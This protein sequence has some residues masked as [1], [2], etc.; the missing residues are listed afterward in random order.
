MA[1]INPGNE[2]Q[3]WSDSEDKNSLGRRAEQAIKRTARRYITK[4]HLRIDLAQEE[5]AIRSKPLESVA[6][7][8]SLGFILGGGVTTRL[9]IVALGTF[10]YRVF[11]EASSAES[12]E[13]PDIVVPQG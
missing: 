12:G 7:A 1:D 6:I 11:R 9:G 5:H 4:A 13:R 3:R 2:S 10:G 8:A